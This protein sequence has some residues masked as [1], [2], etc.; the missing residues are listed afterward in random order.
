[1]D[2]IKLPGGRE[3]SISRAAMRGTYSDCL[4]GMPQKADHSLVRS[5]KEGAS[6]MLPPAEPITIT[7]SP[8]RPLPAYMWVAELTSSRGVLTDDPDFN[9]R[10]Y[11]CWFT[12]GVDINIRNSIASLAHELDWEHEAAD[13]DVT[14]F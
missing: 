14:M 1:M 3:V 8:Q 7:L 2:T 6:R 10:L 11:V 9:S 4:E 13:Y 5:L 12:D